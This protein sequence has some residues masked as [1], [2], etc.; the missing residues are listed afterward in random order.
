MQRL[1]KS[2][3]YHP[4]LMDSEYVLAAKISSTTNNLIS[5][6]V[7]NNSFN[8]VL[9]IHYFTKFTNTLLF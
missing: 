9:D 6:L 1:K 7:L 5:R 3:K 4:V 8:W 2:G